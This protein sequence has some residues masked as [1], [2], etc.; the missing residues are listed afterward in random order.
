VLLADELAGPLFVSGCV[1]NQVRFYDRFDA[2]VLLSAPCDVLLARIGERVTNDF[3]K[4]PG[5]R[6]RVLEDLRTVEPLLRD[7]A[8]IE[9]RQVVGP[10]SS[11]LVLAPLNC[12]A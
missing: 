12:R 1:A 2:V 7:S 6:A 4:R 5:E 9:S 3:G 11:S 10:L 8:T